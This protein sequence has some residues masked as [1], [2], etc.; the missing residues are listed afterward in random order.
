MT[1]DPAQLP[2]AA[3]PGAPETA[4]AAIAV[5]GRPAWVYGGAVAVVSVIAGLAYLAGGVA[6]VW[7]FTTI[8]GRMI[9]GFLVA[10]AHLFYSGFHQNRDVKRIEAL[11][12]A[13]WAGMGLWTSLETLFRLCE[14]AWD[15]QLPP[16]ESEGFGAMCVV[17]LS[18]A[19][20]IAA[21]KYAAPTP[22]TPS[23]K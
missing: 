9:V 19:A 8:F 16:A 13:M 11:P 12:V 18:A 7:L 15:V 14:R 21:F 1:G 23:T 17:F 3:P 6:Q 2:A 20:L 4:A 10:I 22:A 5:A